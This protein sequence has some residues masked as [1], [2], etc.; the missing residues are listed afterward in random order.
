MAR[1]KRSL[2]GL[3]VHVTGAGG[4]IGRAI[5][6]ALARQGTRL[7]L[8]DVDVGALAHV[9]RDI[10]AE[11]GRV[12]TFR[13]DVRD[14]PAFV[15]LNG[16]IERELGPLDVLVN[17]AGILRRGRFA[18][19][20]PADGHD[21]IAVN[22]QGT[23][24]GMRAVMPRMLERGQGQIVNIASLAGRIPMPYAAL[25]SAS[26]HALIGLTDATRAEYQG[27]GLTFSLVLPGYVD[28]PLIRGA[29]P[30]A[31]PPIVHPE[32]VAKGVVR[33]IER[34]LNSCHVPRFLALF[35]ICQLILP[36][37]VLHW[38]GE[39]TGVTH[40]LAAVPARAESRGDGEL[41][42]EPTPG[43]R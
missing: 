14:A 5:A 21:E 39:V 2:A 8:S 41:S 32:A 1:R 28:T 35:P 20:P 36:T 29:R 9:V 30:P 38:L 40:S 6:R 31:F 25:Y 10:E 19:V 12:Q 7:A 15:E 18:D 17:N 43:A 3:C 16:T 23:V 22:L 26:K 11:G 27:S 24:N 37:R 4:G 13:L 42:T 33:T 34:R